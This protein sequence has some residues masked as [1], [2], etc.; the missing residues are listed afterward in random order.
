EDKLT[1]IQNGIDALHRDHSGVEVEIEADTLDQVRGFLTLRDVDYILLDNMTEAERRE[2]VA[3][4][5]DSPV[6]L[7]ASGGIV[8]DNVR[9]VAETGVDFIS[10]G[11]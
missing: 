10:I 2:A 7:E 6:K 8:L 3:L 4:A 5:Q 9:V 1:A 11:A